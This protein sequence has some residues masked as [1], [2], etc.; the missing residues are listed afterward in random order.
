MNGDGIS[1]DLMYIPRDNSEIN[2]KTDADR[3]AYWAFAEQDKYLKNHKGQY[4]EAYSVRNPWTH[5][6]DFRIMEEFQFRVGATTNAIQL[7][8][9]IMNIGNLI[10]S[11]WGVNRVNNYSGNSR[12]LKYEGVNDKNEP[13][14]SMVKVNGAYPTESFQYNQDRSQCWQM[15]IGI[16]YL[17]N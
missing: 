11:K 15:Q 2:F 12:I 8:F 4:A 7:S 3:D 1:N 13:V 10:N 5:R 14:F 9:D 17:F 16:K 6:F